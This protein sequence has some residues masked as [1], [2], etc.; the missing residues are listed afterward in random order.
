MAH[1]LIRIA[2]AAATTAVLAFSAS[3]QSLIRDAEIEE[4]IREWTDPI[5]DVAGLVPE[6]VG[7]YIINDP[8]LNA[9]VANGQRIHIHTGLMI[10]AENANQIK[11][12]IAHETCH[13]ACGHTVSRSRAAGVAMRPALLSIGLGLLA[14]AAGEGGAGAAL[15]GS[16]QQFAALNFFTH[17]RAEEAS[18]DAHA[19]KYLAA[20]GQSPAGIVQFFENFRYQEVMSEARR[21]PYF[22]AH[23]LAADRIRATRAL[24]ESTGLMNVEPTEREVKQYQMLRA[25]LVGFLDSPLKVRRD[26]PAS[27]TSEPARYARAISAYRA[28]DIQSAMKDIESLIAEEPENPY[29]HEL[30]GQILFESGRVA[31]SVAPHKRALELKPGQPLLLISY[32]RSLNA[33]DEEGDVASA[34]SALRDALVAEPD[35]AFAWAQLAITLEKQG[36][37][38]EAQ[39][40]TAESAYWVGDIVR[41]NSFARRAVDQL[42]RGTPNFRRADD[43]LLITDPNNPEN[44]EYYQRSGRGQRL[45][46]EVSGRDMPF[47]DF[48]NR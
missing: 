36:R 1:R 33:R 5:L 32:A 4:T 46:L 43:I 47:G 37:R 30:K 28:A 3:A 15:I 44:R 14:I 41:A 42:D 17:T 6:D 39:L 25:K 22:R 18:A 27:D 24:A 45:S 7:I 21:Y 23:P 19:V 26:Y 10:E 12:V 2:A 35:N 20:L 48:S 13:I 31:E 16:S 34:E 11:G 9:F 38:A 29:F 40:A 8:S